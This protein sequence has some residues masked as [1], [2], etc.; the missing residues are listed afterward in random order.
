M[1]A[2]KRMT[3]KKIGDERVKTLN[4]LPL[5]K[6]HKLKAVNAA[7]TKDGL[8]ICDIYNM[9]NKKRKTIVT[10]RMF[11]NEEFQ[12]DMEKY[13]MNKSWFPDLIK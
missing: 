6:K 10:S 3:T 1:G 2:E 5:F 7:W 13:L 11:A 12:K 4:S 8:T 9:S